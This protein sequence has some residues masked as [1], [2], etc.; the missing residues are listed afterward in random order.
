VVYDALSEFNELSFYSPFY[1][2]TGTGKYLL[3]IFPSLHLLWLL[4]AILLGSIAAI[5][6]LPQ[7]WLSAIIAVIAFLYYQLI[8]F[9]FGKYDHGFTTLTYALLVYPFFLWDTQKSKATV[10]PGWSI[11]L[12]Q[13][14]LCLSYF[15]C[16]MEKLFISGVDWFYSDNLKQL[17]LIH[18][19]TIGLQLSMHPILCQWLSFGVVAMQCSFIALPF[20]KKLRYILLPAG[21]IFHSATWLLLDAGGWFNPWWGMYLF[22]LFP[23]QPQETK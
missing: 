3:P 14:L 4:Y 2:P 17:L 5:L 11:V 20:Y 7:K 12:I 16:G 22:F 1:N 8:L 10:V 13:L 18:P 19:S 9:G 6:F 23:L 21:F 15:Y